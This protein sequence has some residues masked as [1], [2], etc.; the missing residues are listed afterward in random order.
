MIY[1]DYF[2]PCSAGLSKGDNKIRYYE[3]SLSITIYLLA[4]GSLT[5]SGIMWKLESK[6]FEHLAL[7]NQGLLK[8][9]TR[10]RILLNQ[11]YFFNLVV[12]CDAW[13]ILKL[14]LEQVVTVEFCLTC[15]KEINN[16][17]KLTLPGKQVMA[18][19]LVTGKVVTC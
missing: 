10:R 15:I 11:H 13:S 18:N 12:F 9:R 3:T 17:S 7:I 16:I 8:D 2:I 6:Y 14:L 1:Y 19:K 4:Y 5:N